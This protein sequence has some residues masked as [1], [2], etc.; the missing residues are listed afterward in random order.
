MT[1]KIDG[2][3]TVANP[4]FT[5]ADTDTGLQVGTN[6]LKLVTGGTSAV[7]LDSSQHVSLEKAGEAFHAIR[8]T[9][10][11]A[12]DDYL[13][14]VSWKGNNSASEDTEYV[15]VFAQA[16][17][18]TDGTE[19][20]SLFLASQ[21]AGS[22][23]TGLEIAS[24]YALTPGNP[25]IYLDALDW[26]NTN[27]YMHNGHQF[28]QVGNHWNNTNGT[29]TCPVGGKY[30]VAADVQGHNT[31]LQTGADDTYFNIMP[32]INNGSYGLETVA[33]S[34]GDSGGA[35]QHDSVGFAIIASVNANDTIRVYSNHGFRTNTQNHLTIYLLG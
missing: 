7:T 26:T 32:R 19:D 16:K 12:D 24:G 10:T 27:N 3:N 6:E 4:A 25:G 13:G 30:L 33:T 15:K 14:A 17:D 18:V 2:T 11:L 9:G 8:R 20:G 29:F 5:G 21:R 34:K 31:H 35:G 22:M 1:V 23:T 28:W